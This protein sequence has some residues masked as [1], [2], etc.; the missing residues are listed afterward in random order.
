MLSWATQLESGMGMWLFPLGVLSSYTSVKR[1]SE[2]YTD[3]QM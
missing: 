3:L 2:G 1:L